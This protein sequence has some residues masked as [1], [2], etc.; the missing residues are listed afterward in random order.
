MKKKIPLIFTILAFTALIPMQ[1]YALT[2]AEELT[3]ALQEV[4]QPPLKSEPL[5]VNIKVTDYR[6]VDGHL[7]DFQIEYEAKIP[8]LRV[9]GDL[10]TYHEEL[11]QSRAVKGLDKKVML[12]SHNTIDLKDAKLLGRH[13]V[14]PMAKEEW[15]MRIAALEKARE[16]P[17]HPLTKEGVNI[18]F[19]ILKTN[20]KEEI[21]N[22]EVFLNPTEGNK[23]LQFNVRLICSFTEGSFTCNVLLENNGRSTTLL[24]KNSEK[25]IVE[26][27]ENIRQRDAATMMMAQSMIQMFKGYAGMA[28]NSQ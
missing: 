20:E 1:S 14:K 18:E 13:P 26:I 16:S 12:T 27:L 8:A 22:F 17:N 4:I 2:P 6:V 28:L 5:D 10:F 24:D 3:E 11:S 25:Q 7:A 19:K 23:T 9:G 21:E 15:E